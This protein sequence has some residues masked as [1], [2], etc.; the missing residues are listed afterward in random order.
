MWT[1]PGLLV[2]V[3]NKSQHNMFIPKPKENCVV[4]SKQKGVYFQF[5]FQVLK[6][7]VNSYISL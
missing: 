3:N 5:K 1:G 7:T 4:Y 2:C 6:M